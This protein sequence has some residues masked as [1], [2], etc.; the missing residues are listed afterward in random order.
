MVVGEGEVNLVQNE[1]AVV[2]ELDAQTRKS[3]QFL[4]LDANGLVS[5]VHS[6]VLCS[7]TRRNQ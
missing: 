3:I 4:V 6:A 5:V 1:D 7:K 2:K